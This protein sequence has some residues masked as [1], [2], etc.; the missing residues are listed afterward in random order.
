LAQDSDWT[1]VF[2]DDVAHVYVRRAGPNAALAERLV[3]RR[4]G[5]DTEATAASDPRAA[6]AASDLLAELDRAIAQS[7]ATIALHM[8]RAQARE[9]QGNQAGAEADLRESTRLAPD[10]AYLWVRLG[11]FLAGQGR[12]VEAREALAQAAARTPKDR[13]TRVLLAVALETAGDHEAAVTMLRSLAVGESAEQLLARLLR[14]GLGSPP[15][16]RE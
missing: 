2:I 10:M 6:F 4:L 1:L 9:A 16:H 5:R 15:N 3:Y 14:S 13:P 7:T 12:L 8:M 11:S